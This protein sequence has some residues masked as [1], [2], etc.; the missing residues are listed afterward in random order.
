MSPLVPPT[1]SPTGLPG[2]RSGVVLPFRLAEVAGASTALAGVIFV[3]VQ[4]GHPG[5]GTFTTETGEW[6]ARSVAKTVMAA[7]A[8]VG[9]TGMYLHQRRAL[10]VV[11]L[12]GYL[13]LACGY[14]AM[15]SVEVI[16]ST[17]LPALVETAP[18]FVD[19]VVA[20]ATGE[21]TVGDIGSLRVLFA[22]AG[23]GYLLGGLLLG[24]ALLRNGV[25]ARW[26]AALLALGT[27]S[28]ACL[29]FLPEAFNRPMAVPVGV[30][31][32]GLGV[33]SYRLDR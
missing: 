5:P 18:G 10:G 17:V 23:A 28:T 6:V 26:A 25:L 3:A 33:S 31:L 8:L 20:A 13:V 14:L 7:L 22:I 9:I 11:G 15:F 1:E 19:D 16:A 30:A 27:V 21:R 32:I 2:Q 4:I 12:L 24:L 29:A